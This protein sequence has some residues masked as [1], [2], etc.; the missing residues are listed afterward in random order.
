VLIE[1]HFS[2]KQAHG[3]YFI[4]KSKDVLETLEANQLRRKLH[5][6]SIKHAAFKITFQ[7]DRRG[8]RVDLSGTNKISFNRQTHASNCFVS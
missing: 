7:D 6:G 5:G 8:K 3:P 1:L 2:L 4:V